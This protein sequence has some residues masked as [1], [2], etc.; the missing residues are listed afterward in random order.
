MKKL[1]LLLCL[2]VVSSS[3]FAIREKATKKAKATK[4]RRAK[5]KRSR[6]KGF[7]HPKGKTKEIAARPMKYAGQKFEG[8]KYKKG[9]GGWKVKGG[10]LGAVKI[11][12]KGK[13][14]VGKGF[15]GFAKTPVKGGWKVKGKRHK[16]AAEVLAS[17]PKFPKKTCW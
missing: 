17:Q 16:S 1:S 8:F 4:I 5:L 6:V 15:T 11:G 7:V 12:A 13:R 10:K 2:A 9:K 3:V 14:F